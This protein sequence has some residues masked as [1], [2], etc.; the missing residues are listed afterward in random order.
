MA[1]IGEMSYINKG[2]REDGY[3][4]WQRDKQKKATIKRTPEQQQIVDEYF[5]IKNYSTTTANSTLLA[6]KFVFQVAF[7]LFLAIM[8]ITAVTAEFNSTYLIIAIVSFIVSKI[9]EHFY[10]KSVNTVTAPKKVMTDEEYEALVRQKIEDMNVKEM[11]LNRLGLDPDQVAEI[12]PIV[13]RD[14]TRTDESLV[15]YNDKKGKLYSS[16]QYVFYLFF[17]DDQLLVY[18]FQFDMCCNLKDEWTSEFF[19]K[20]ICDVSSHTST[21]IVTVGSDSG[22]KNAGETNKLGAEKNM[23]A[24][25]KQ[26][27]YSELEFT[28]IASNSSIGFTMDASKERLESVQAMKQKIR[29]KKAM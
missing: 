12:Q 10:K 1:K 28:I 11:G 8:V 7:W 29:E 18:K 22:N 13:F 23:N 21:N 9:A 26:I 14:K 2:P 19:Y 17:T 25:A 3:Y 5:I 24:R 16:T 4:R 20:D 15:V 6:L 27:E